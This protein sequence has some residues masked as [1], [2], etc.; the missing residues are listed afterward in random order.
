M[1][2]RLMTKIKILCP[3]FSCHMLIAC[4]IFLQCFG[5]YIWSSFLDFSASDC[6][7]SV[8]FVFWMILAIDPKICSN[9]FIF[10][11]ELFCFGR[12]WLSCMWTL[13]CSW[14]FASWKEILKWQRKLKRITLS[15]SECPFVGRCFAHQTQYRW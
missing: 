2:T 1:S 12:N 11:L 5:N 13:F 3:H 14:R 4:R 8:V 6:C 15:L 7:V 10:V 9:S